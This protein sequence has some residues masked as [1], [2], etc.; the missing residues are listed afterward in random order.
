MTPKFKNFIQL[1]WEFRILPEDTLTCRLEESGINPLTFRLLDDPLHH[2]SHRIKPACYPTTAA[3]HPQQMP[4]TVES[5]HATPP[6]TAHHL[7]VLYLSTSTTKISQTNCIA[8]KSCKTEKTLIQRATKWLKEAKQ[9]QKPQKM[10][11]TGKV[12]V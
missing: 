4:T 6:G 10:C 2:L 5:S 7:T 1:N 8:A 9:M 11:A 12:L 3:D